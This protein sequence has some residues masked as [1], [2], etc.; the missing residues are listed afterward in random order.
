MRSYRK[1][2]LIAW[3]DALS[4][5]RTRETIASVLVFSILVIVIFNFAFV[6]SP[7]A[8]NLLAPGILWATFAFAGVLALNHSFTLEKEDG[9]LEGLMACPVGREV[10]YV[11]KAL[12]SLLFLLFIEIVVLLVFALLFN[13]TVVTPQMIAI[14]FLTTLGFVSVGSLFSAMAVS[15]R[16]RETV[17]PILFFPTVTPIIICA[18]KASALALAGGAWGN[19][20]IWLEIIA[21]FDVIFLV[22]SFLVFGFV[23]EE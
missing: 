20:V 9:C 8:I 3:K 4:E 12:G 18:V 15:T 7:E 16:A 23:V 2:L 19:L 11:G 5:I 13:Q 22:A 17:L 10:I 21:A 14:T 6:A 1:A